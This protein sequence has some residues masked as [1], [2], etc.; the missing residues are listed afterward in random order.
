MSAKTVSFRYHD[1][2]FYHHCIYLRAVELFL[3]LHVI[4]IVFLHRIVFYL[5]LSTLWKKRS[6][7]F[8]SWLCATQNDQDG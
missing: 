2:F 4:Y 8:S 6:S 5:L 1:E 7:P 3:S